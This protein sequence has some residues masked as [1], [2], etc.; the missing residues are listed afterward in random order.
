MAPEQGKVV[1]LSGKRPQS[2]QQLLEDLYA[3]YG[4]ALSAFMQMR[5]NSP[6]ESEDLVQDLFY[7]LA[8][9]DGVV[10]KLTTHCNQRAYLFAM[11][12]NLLV[13]HVRK[14]KRQ[15]TATLPVEEL[16][17]SAMEITPETITS[18]DQELAKLK[19]IL[20]GLTP[21]CRTAFSLKRFWH[22][23]S[24]QVGELM[25]ISASRV[26]KYIDRAMKA[27]QTGMDK[28]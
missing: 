21:Q 5:L 13:D 23:T 19:A 6:D 10:E 14:A 17:E 4:H 11:A 25:G 9:M 8:R 20:A 24:R 28:P 22:L 7:K 3:K 2:R 16:P 1:H 15:P 12:N 26:E 27:L 18:A